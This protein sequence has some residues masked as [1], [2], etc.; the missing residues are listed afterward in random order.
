VKAAVSLV[1]VVTWFGGSFP[2][3]GAGAPDA[4]GEEK[5]SLDRLVVKL[6]SS[7]PQVREKA[8]KALLERGAEARPAVMRAMKSDD[9]ELRAGAARVLLQLPWYLPDDSPNVRGL[10]AQYGQFDVARRVQVV[11]GLAQQRNHGFDALARLIVEE[12]SDEVKWT[13]V[14]AVRSN[15]REPVL[16][17]FRRLVPEGPIPTAGVSAPLLAAA[18]HAWF[19]KDL[20][21]GAKLLRAAVDLDARRPADD[22]GELVWAYERVGHALLLSGKYQEMAELLR[23]RA[24][25]APAG[26]ADRND[27]DGLD[28]PPISVLELFA[29]HARFGP[30]AGFDDDARRHQQWLVDPRVMYCVSQTYERSGNSA[31][32]VAVARG[33]RACT[34]TVTDA[35]QSTGLFLLGQGWHDMAEGEFEAVLAEEPILTR[36][37]AEFRLALVGAARD[38]DSDAATHLEQG[39]KLHE[40]GGGELRF[41]SDREQWQEVHWRYLRAANRRADQAEANARLGELMKDA[42]ALDNPDVV[43]DVVPMLRR[44]GRDKEADEMFRRTYDLLK[45]QVA[46]D[47]T[48]H[49]R[50]KNN[51]A[52]LIARCGPDE[53]QA[54]GLALAQSASGSMP[55]NAAFMDTL[56]EAYFRAGQA[57]KAA[58][59]ERKV[60]LLRPGDRFLEGQLKK[61]EGAAAR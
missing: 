26:D 44:V 56:A 43:N 9:P 59:I 22:G 4:T 1:V 18:G 48:E 8:V 7:D 61:F 30:L 12:P 51:L 31:L 55:D 21:R 36:A 6:G 42:A 25:R 16:E 58:E 53:K 11:R 15:F 60:V 2:A 41:S 40:A 32:A 39:M 3:F 46:T 13:I 50:H 10:L 45:Q 52:W 23:Q 33:A 38:D 19:T 37:N 47:P 49:P 5:V 27:E 54:E 34:V 57:T 29:L 35:R 17:Q 24:S 28:S 20:E 14:T